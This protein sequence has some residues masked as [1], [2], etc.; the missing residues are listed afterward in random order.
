MQ[1]TERDARDGGMRWSDGCD[2][3]MRWMALDGWMDAMDGGDG[4]MV[5]CDD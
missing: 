5:G 2:V 4:W 1:T 3:W